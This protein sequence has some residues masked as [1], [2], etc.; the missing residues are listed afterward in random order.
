MSNESQTS[1]NGGEPQIPQSA[2]R[3]PLLRS[4]TRVLTTV[5]V[6]LVLLL[7]VVGMPDA[8]V[9][10]YVTP[11]NQHGD[12]LTPGAPLVPGDQITFDISD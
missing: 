1:P 12:I 2:S 10:L 9:T 6:S 5:S 8:T 4:F 7:G 3:M 11:T